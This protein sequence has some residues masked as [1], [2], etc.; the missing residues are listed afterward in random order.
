MLKDCSIHCNIFVNKY[1]SLKE[2]YFCCN[3][4]HVHV[5]QLNN[6]KPFVAAFIILYRM[7]FLVIHINKPNR[8]RILPVELLQI[9]SI[10]IYSYIPIEFISIENG[11]HSFISCHTSS[12]HKIMCVPSVLVVVA[13]EHFFSLKCIWMLACPHFPPFHVPTSG[14]VSILDSFEFMV[15]WWWYTFR[16]PN[17]FADNTDTQNHLRAFF[18]ASRFSSYK[19]F[20]CAHYCMSFDNNGNKNHIFPSVAIW[21]K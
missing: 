14:L 19:N 17:L 9:M 13:H 11:T 12:H 1:F 15:T 3:F 18:L 5:S 20:Y 10:A 2:V 6:R 8:I 7:F 4:Y 16:I 21:N